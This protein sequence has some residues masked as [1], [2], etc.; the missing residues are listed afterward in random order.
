[1]EFDFGDVVLSIQARVLGLQRYRTYR[2]YG[3]P[4]ESTAAERAVPAAP[5]RPTPERPMIGVQMDLKA[6]QSVDAR[7]AYQDERGNPVSTPAGA[8]AAWEVDRTDLVTVTDN[9]DGSA[10]FT[11]AGPLGQAIV[12]VTADVNGRVVTGNDIIT[13]VAGDAE[14]VAVEFDEPRETTPDDEPAPEPTPEV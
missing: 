7:L 3:V 13:V 14:R 10:T 2:H 4:R 5:M 12:T 1:M 11:A 9:G 8:T 6:D